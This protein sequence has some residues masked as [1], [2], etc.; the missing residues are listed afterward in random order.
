MSFHGMSSSELSEPNAKVGCPLC[1]KDFSD[2]DLA[3]RT[4]HTESCLELDSSGPSAEHVSRKIVEQHPEIELDQ[5]ADTFRRLADCPVCGKAWPFRDPS[6]ISH[7][8]QCAA[9]YS[10]SA[11]DLYSLIDVFKDSLDSSSSL[12]LPPEKPKQ[13]Q[14]KKPRTIDGWVNQHTGSGQ[15]AVEQGSPS[16]QHITKS[17]AYEIPGDDDFQSTR[18]TV[19]KR[20]SRIAINRLTKKQQEFMD[21]L[22]EDLIAAKALSLSLKRNIS[23]SV[24]SEYPAKKRESK[25]KKVARLERS[26]ILACADAQD[27]IRQRA[28]ALAYLDEELGI[29]SP[30]PAESPRKTTSKESSG[31]WGL[32]ASMTSDHEDCPIFRAYN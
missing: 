14:A 1:G 19:P 15:M 13:A 22:D 28:V 5:Y 24:V 4:A 7:V 21:E 23:D 8:K 6:R 12:N 30:R 9:R 32:S 17:F 16:Y 10:V 2:W 25:D 11:T 18:I 3:A 20:Q 31:L 26:D 27:Y 29:V